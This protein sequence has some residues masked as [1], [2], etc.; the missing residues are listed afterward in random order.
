MIK[1]KNAQLNNDTIEALNTLVDSD[2][3][4]SVAFK[5]TRI[6]KEISSIIEDKLKLEKKI[7]D[8]WTE[9]DADGNPVKPLDENNQP[10]ENSVKISN[11]DEFTREMNDLLNVENEIGYEKIKFED[12]KLETAKVKD[13]LK[14]EFL[15]D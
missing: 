15:F 11:V 7:L 3:N 2:I 8:K 13:L 14:L 5:L 9:K 6:I 4:A 10:I 12:L 1:I